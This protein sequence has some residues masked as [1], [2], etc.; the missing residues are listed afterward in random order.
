MR[1]G[2]V[3]AGPAGLYFAAL[4]K[5][6]DPSHEITILE[7][8]A[9]DAT[10]GWG[11]VFSE[12][13][14]SE[15]RD[16][17]YETYLGF[18]DHLVRWDA[19]DIRYRD[20]TMRSVGHGFSAI[21]RKTLL[22]LL[23]GRCRD[24]GVDMRFGVEA[25]DVEMFSGYDLI[26]G[27]DGVNSMVRTLHAEAFRPRL[28]VHATRYA[29][30]GTPLVFDAFTFIFRETP[31]GLFQVHAYPFDGST[32]TFIVETTAE[33]WRNAG[34]DR[35]GEEES[36]AYCEELFVDHLGG[37]KLLSN[38]SL[39]TSFVTVSNE[40]WHHGNV[41]LL[42]DAVA[43]A[44][45]SIGSGTKLAIEGAV[46]L[47]K[48]FQVH[49]GDLAA[50]FAEYEMERQPAVERFQRA[51]RDS[52][53]YFE[54]VSRYLAF[55][56]EQ[57]A[58]NLLTRSGRVTHLGLEMRDPAIINRV[59]RLLAAG[60]EERV[61][62]RLM[63]ARPALAPLNLGGITLANRLVLAPRFDHDAHGGT[64]GEGAATALVAAAGQGAGLVVTEPV[65]V[66]DHA[67][68]TSGS[69]GLYTVEHVG[70]WR[71]L[72]GASHAAGAAMA[73]RLG[74]GGRRGATR[75]PRLA[76]DWPLPPDTAPF[77]LLAPSALPY[78][79]RSQVPRAMTRQDL[80]D[81][82]VDF[83][84]A[85]GRAADAG[86]DCL[87]LDCS[88]GYLLAS[89]LSP[90]TN[91]R[92]DEY[93]GSREARWRYPLEVYRAVRDAWPRD[94]PLG[95]RLAAT[96]WLAAGW[97]PDDAVAFATALVG[98]G[99]ALVDVAAG[100]VVPR[101]APDYRRQYLVPFA[102]R[103]RNEAGVATVVAGNITTLDE[104]DTIVA[105]GRADLVVLDAGVY[106]SSSSS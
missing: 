100:G 31:H 57:F 88:D 15:L 24:L 42:G 30:F 65:A 60:V 56:P 12:E 28:D 84:A 66:S 76:R 6:A 81:V 68:V 72:V 106:Y 59:D 11:V 23:Q 80:D 104:V 25:R 91:Q 79:P 101:G 4:M 95:V 105:A 83:A 44:H 85:A 18:Q 51:A 50:A 22:A 62:D 77:G 2:I 64:P 89:F 98:E 55:D 36:L 73:V 34:L 99:C 40:S 43:T 37:H 49:P 35:L 17:D 7:R 96:D 10:F 41:V 20:G 82:R 75:P 26:V 48:A 70:A 90:L 52:A 63:V 86:V 71:A 78:T 45:F 92:G 1:I 13:T 32:S 19:I 93:G 74:H 47:A 103:I 69:A 3:G 29:W 33:T 5:D 9:P 102:D 67:R 61:R 14:L 39:W 38:R 21:S 53:S 8:N 16:A 54:T 58:F 46:A 27:A 97:Q 87:L 94:R